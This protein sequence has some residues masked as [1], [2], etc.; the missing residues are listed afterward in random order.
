[1]P[2][3]LCLVFFIWLQT[4]HHAQLSDAGEPISRFLLGKLDHLPPGTGDPSHLP[5]LSSVTPPSAQAGDAHPQGRQNSRIQEVAG[6][7]G[8]RRVGTQNLA[9]HLGEA[10]HRRWCGPPP[11]RRGPAV[12]NAPAPSPYCGK[13]CCIH[14][15]QAPSLNKFECTE[16]W[17][18]VSIIS[19]SSLNIS[20]TFFFQISFYPTV[21]PFHPPPQ[22]TSSVY[23]EDGA[24]RVSEMG[25]G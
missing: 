14:H 15:C 7:S 18:A 22:Q 25:R 20:L 1:M 3:C 8:S 16:P 9:S 11:S 12:L 21:S 2:L 10:R 19:L 17:A 23:S 24:S 13:S 6:E 5:P 4:M